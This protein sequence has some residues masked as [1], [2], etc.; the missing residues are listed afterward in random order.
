[1]MTRVRKLGNKI[2]L[3]TAAIVWSACSSDLVREEI[4][5]DKGCTLTV[6]AIKHETANTRALNPDGNKIFTIWNESDRVT[7]LSANNSVIGTMTPV[8]IEG[9]KA[10]LKATLTSPV[11]KG[12]ALTLVFPRTGRDYTGQKGT[13]ADIASNYDYAEAQVVVQYADESFVSATDALFTNQQAIVKF[14][15][16]NT[17]AQPIN[18][19]GLT[20]T[21]DGLIQKGGSTGP[22]TITPTNA[23]NEIYA[24]LSGLD[25]VVTLTA[26]VD[27]KTYSYVSTEAKKLDNSGF[28]R[29]NVKMKPPTV[30]YTEPLTLECYDKQGG[31]IFVTDYVDLE[32]SR[33]GGNWLSVPAKNQITIRSGDRISFRGT[34]STKGTSS[35]KYMQ[36]NC[37]ADCYI[38][39]NVMSLLSKDNYATMKE[40]P[41]SNTFQNLFK[42][43]THITH[44]DGKDLVLPATTLKKQC[45]YQMFYGCNKLNYIKCLAT[46]ISASNC[47]ANWL[48]KAGTAISGAHVFVKAAGF[49]GWPTSSNSGIPDRWKVE[50]E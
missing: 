43:N 38:Y 48:A 18:A 9:N 49:D 4:L 16:T 19:S 12:D 46:D 28:Y 21:A 6:N 26:T 39:G 25:G 29:F 50:E 41:Y 30:A 20:I 23:T 2:L 33:N 13:L 22:V 8:N 15:L 3:L 35:G 36:I 44:A 1:M 45:Y 7:V 32:Y 31:T 17:K 10:K 14:N 24:A 34:E 37:N 11:R 27:N 40:L 42:D 47:T 5:S